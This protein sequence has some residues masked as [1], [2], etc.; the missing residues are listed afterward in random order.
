MTYSARPSDWKKQGFTEL[1][2][3][4]ERNGRTIEYIKDGFRQFMHQK[5]ALQRKIAQQAVDGQKR[6][7]KIDGHK[8]NRKISS[9]TNSFFI[10]SINSCFICIL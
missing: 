2:I 10:T 5:S 9:E 3:M 1:R 4:G 8:W 6:T 7:D